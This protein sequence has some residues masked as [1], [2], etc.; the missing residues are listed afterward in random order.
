MINK[1][2]FTLD[3]KTKSCRRNLSSDFSPRYEDIDKNTKK[4]QNKISLKNKSAPEKSNV[5]SKI[6]HTNLI[7][8]IFITK[9][10]EYESD[11]TWSLE[12]A[13]L[14]NDTHQCLGKQISMKRESLRGSQE[15]ATSINERL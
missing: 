11:D 8:E 7:H 10:V 6:E 5:K 2:V 13:T 15:E 12:E 1:K 9:N 14:T 4:D 3:S